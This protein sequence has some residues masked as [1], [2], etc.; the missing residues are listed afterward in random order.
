MGVVEG[1]APWSQILETASF[2]DALAP[3][4]TGLTGLDCRLRSLAGSEDG[5][6][7]RN[8]ANLFAT[9]AS[10]WPRPDDFQS[11]Y[12]PMMVLADGQRTVIPSDLTEQDL[13]VLAAVVDALP[14]HVFRSRVLDVLAL[15]ETD[16]YVRSATQR[17]CGR[18]WRTGCSDRGR[19]AASTGRTIRDVLPTRKAQRR[20]DPRSAALQGAT[21]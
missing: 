5:D 8:L 15:L 1:G 9:V 11:P 6:D 3:T 21:G 2:Q 10:F 14:E 4:D 18:S 13:L 12:G 17:R 16:L 7:Q 19:D 20:A